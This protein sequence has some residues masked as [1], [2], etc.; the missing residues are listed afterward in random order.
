MLLRNVGMYS[1]Y[2]ALQPTKDRTL[3]E[4]MWAMSHFLSRTGHNDSRG[5][6]NINAN[7]QHNIHVY[8]DR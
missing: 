2:A 3:Q 8:K 4:F 7:P 1:N 5:S 6:G